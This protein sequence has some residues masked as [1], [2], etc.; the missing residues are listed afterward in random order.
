MMKSNIDFNI[1]SFAF[2]LNKCKACTTALTIGHPI[3]RL[4]SIIRKCKFMKVELFRL[5]SQVKFI[6]PQRYKHKT[7]AGNSERPHGHLS[8]P[9]RFNNTPPTC[10]EHRTEF[11][12]DEELIFI[13][14][15]SCV[16]S[17][18]YLSN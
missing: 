18:I 3:I 12:K 7:Q 13:Q 5:S 1:E 11:L 10:R 15:M 17:I 6:L 4:G 14:T 2:L 16:S 9:H 8:Q